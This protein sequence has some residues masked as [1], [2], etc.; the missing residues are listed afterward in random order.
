MQ[1]KR[2]SLGHEQNRSLLKP[3]RLNVPGNN[4][5][6]DETSMAKGKSDIH[7]SAD[8]LIGEFTFLSVD[9]AAEAAELGGEEEIDFPSVEMTASTLRRLESDI[10]QVR[11][12]WQNVERALQART[13]RISGL[14]TE[15]DEKDSRIKRLEEG[16]RLT[17]IEQRQLIEEATASRDEWQAKFAMANE[18]NLKAEA[19][20]QAMQTE[21]ETLEAEVCAK[22]DLIEV[23]ANSQ[24]ADRKMFDVFDQSVD[25]IA[26]VDAATE[27]LDSID[28]TSDVDILS[29]HAQYMIVAIDPDG[30]KEI[31][32]PLY[33]DEMTIGRSRRADIQIPNMY[34]SRMHARISRQGSKAIIQDTGSTNGFL[35]NSEASRRRE[36]THGDR[37]NIGTMEFDFVDLSVSQ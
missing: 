5:N 28:S 20:C 35:V 27:G 22:R 19:A 16:L 29:S 24:K 11:S 23:L 13:T 9:N 36:L 21:I 15:L 2:I 32:Y 25:R 14:M 8:K 10:R 17:R 37:L 3:Q 4:K 6:T 31:C 33:K 1:N 18:K 7:T 26:D 30:G 12:T 34:I